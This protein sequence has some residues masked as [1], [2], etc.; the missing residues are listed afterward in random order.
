MTA[1]ARELLDTIERLRTDGR[2]DVFDTSLGAWSRDDWREVLLDLPLDSDTLLAQFETSW[3]VSIATLE[4]WCHRFR[5]HG[6]AQQDE[7]LFGFVSVLVLTMISLRHSELRRSPWPG[8]EKQAYTVLDHA[9]CAHICQ[10]LVRDRAVRNALREL[11]APPSAA[12]GE[13]TIEE[14]ESIDFG[15]VEFHRHGTTSF[16]L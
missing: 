14:W 13:I 10:R 3:D 7:R 8:T 11:Y 16:I 1:T 15:T 6:E 2:D 9:N 12:P 5:E 4:Q